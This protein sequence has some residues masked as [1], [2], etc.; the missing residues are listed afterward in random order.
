MAK[1]A[2]PTEPLKASTVPE[3][4]IARRSHDDEARERRY[5]AE[6]AL[7]TMEKAEQHRKDKSLMRDV[8][9]L[10]KEKVKCLSKIK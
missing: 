4:T 1:K 3:A 9:Q 5:M 8:K 7:R 10:A 2:L 6:D